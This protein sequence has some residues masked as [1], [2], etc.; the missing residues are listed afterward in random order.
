MFARTE[1]A[2]QVDYIHELLTKTMDEGLRPTEDVMKTL[3]QSSNCHEKYYGLL[4]DIEQKEYDRLKKGYLSVVKNTVKTDDKEFLDNLQKIINTIRHKY[5]ILTKVGSRIIKNLWTGYIDDFIKENEKVEGLSKDNFYKTIIDAHKYGLIMVQLPSDN[6]PYL[7]IIVPA[8]LFE[9]ELRD[10]I[11]IEQQTQK[12]ISPQLAQTPLIPT[13][14]QIIRCESTDFSRPPTKEI[15]EHVVA[16]ALSSLGFKV[17][18]DIGL[19]NKAG[20]DVE[21]DVWG[22]KGILRVYVS[23]K[24]WNSDVGR[25]VIDEEF[26]RTFNLSEVPHLRIIVAKNLSDEAKK[27]AIADGFFVIELGNKVNESNATDMCNFLQG[28]LSKI[29]ISMTPPQ[30]LTTKETFD[31]IVNSLREL[32]NRVA[33]LGKILGIQK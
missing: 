30:L 11:K 22:T 2:T 21:V 28:E 17:Y 15:L 19:R 20:S 5:N 24:N 12:A 18:T 13:N 16:T 29:F 32:E 14:M 6:D 33:D 25:N 4:E 26:G 1:L 23:C 7:T 31:S 3:S 10:L 8:P 27:T 9:K